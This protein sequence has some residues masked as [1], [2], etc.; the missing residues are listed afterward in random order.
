MLELAV[1]TVALFFIV[2]A[3]FVFFTSVVSERAVLHIQPHGRVRFFTIT[4]SAALGAALLFSAA[5]AALAHTRAIVMATVYFHTLM[6]GPIENGILVSGWTGLILSL[7]VSYLFMRGGAMPRLPRAAVTERFNG[8]PVL[9]TDII[10]GAGLFGI[11]RPLILISNE[12]A[13]DKRKRKIT[14]THEFTHFRLR[15]NAIRLFFRALLRLNIFNLPLYRIVRGLTLDCEYECDRLTAK[16]VGEPEYTR[17]LESL[18]DGL[19]DS[20]VE[21]HARQT[22]MLRLE[23]L[24]DTPLREVS[25]IAAG[26]MSASATSHAFA[27]YVFSLVPSAI[28]IALLSLAAA[29]RCAI[30]CFLGY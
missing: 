5:M 9:R 19:G 13:A 21:K 22:L 11:F 1:K 20:T 27:A 30:V 23:A 8:V 25:S 14:L 28:L 16:A 3:A 4:H 15:H 17:Y 6:D 12:F 24:K 7:G 2:Q 26:A 18:A 10:R 29:P